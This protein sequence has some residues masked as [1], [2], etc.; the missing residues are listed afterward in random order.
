MDESIMQHAKKYCKNL[1]Q[2][3]RVDCT[4]TDC[5]M[6]FTCLQQTEQPIF[7]EYCENIRGNGCCSMRTFQ[8]GCAES[9][10]WNNTCISLC[11]MGM[12]LMSSCLTEKNGELCGGLTIGPLCMGNMEDILLDM[13]T[14]E[15]RD[16]AM[17]M[18][19]FTSAEVQSLSEILAAVTGYITGSTNSKAGGYFLKQEEML[20]ALFTENIKKEAETDYYIYP[21]AQERKLRSAVQN[22]DAEEAKNILNQILAYMYQTNH[23]SL[24]QIRP[25][26]LE[27]L[28][29]LSRTAMDTGADMETIDLLTRDIGRRI[30]R[31]QNIEELT[32]W[33]AALLQ[34]FMSATFTKK[35]MPHAESVY[36]ITRYIQKNY[37]EKIEL[38]DIADH[39]HMTRSYLC[40]FFKKE[41]GETIIN[42]TNRVRINNSKLLL[43][44]TKVPLAEV[45][46]LCGFEDQSYF[47]KV[48]RG[49]VG[50]TPLKYRENRVTVRG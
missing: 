35:N 18:P 20:N 30:E 9:Y 29:V 4:V 38:Q 8:N 34:N 36:K 46:L 17:Q 7:C 42:Y 16:M 26:I 31:F 50:M 11:A 15:L 3:F 37:R 27:L 24:E 6:P 13:P 28:I 40:R 1:R 47:T 2:L 10:R 41:T 12:V 48:F 45:A 44:D 39:L 32:A 21:I 43:A 23:Y 22:Q 14:G 25:R 49:F 19:L 5:S 33:V